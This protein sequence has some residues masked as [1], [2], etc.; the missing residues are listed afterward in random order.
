MNYWQYENFAKSKYFLLIF[1]F[2]FQL[3]L[4]SAGLPQAA[5]NSTDLIVDIYIKSKPLKNV[6]A[7][8]Q[9]QTGYKVELNSIDESLIVTGQYT[10]I[11][12]DD[13]FFNLLKEHNIS[14]IINPTNKLISVISLGGKIQVGNSAKT[15]ESPPAVTANFS[16]HELVPTVIADSTATPSDDQFIE[17]PE[18][19]SLSNQD[20]LKMHYEQMREFERE[21]NGPVTIDTFTG[22]KSVQLQKEEKN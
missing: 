1:Y 20:I 22:M 15:T 8:I 21:Q 13:I 10:N 19:T 17:S 3:S 11:E 16:K 18:I 6:V 12:V 5:E 9:R 4:C 14:V 7:L 2:S